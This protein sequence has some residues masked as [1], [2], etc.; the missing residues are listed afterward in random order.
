MGLGFNK[1]DRQ[2]G[3]YIGMVTD[4]RKELCWQAV[5]KVVEVGGH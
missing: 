1:S 4:G 5:E 3:Y 2:H